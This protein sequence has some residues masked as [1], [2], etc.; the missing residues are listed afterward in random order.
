MKRVFTV[1]AAVVVMLSLT[2][3][4][5]AKGTTINLW[6]AGTE[7]PFMKTVNEEIL[8]LFRRAYPN[9]DLVVTFVPWGDLSTKL[10]TAFAAK[11]PP[12]VF[13][14]GQAA[15]AGFAANQSI[16]PL[17]K[18]I[19]KMPDAKDFGPTIDSGAYMG[20]RYMLPMNGAGRLLIY[21][22]DF[23]REAGLDPNRPPTT[24]E[25][26]RAAAIAQTI[27]QGSR[28]VREG[29]DIP[30]QGIDAQQIYSN[31]LWQNGGDFI[32]QDGKK[33]IFNSKEGVE[34]L[35]FIVDLIYKDKCTN[36]QEERPLGNVQP[37]ASGKVAMQFAVPND[38]KLIEVYSPDVYKQIRV[39]PPLMNKEQVALYSY[40]GLFMAKDSKNKDAAWEVMQF[41][42]SPAVLGKICESLGMLP[43]RQS[44]KSAPFI[45]KDYRIQAYVEGMAYGRG[46]PNVPAWV[47]V[48]DILAT[49]IEKAAFGVMSPQDALDKAAAEC[50]AALAGK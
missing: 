2:S 40:S 14:H 24:W 28:I 26:L 16:E 5:Y 39:A 31:F 7:A 49:Y 12:D 22:A 29:L 35:Q 46:N 32:S 17:D 44:L 20:K 15:T 8:P 36:T 42:T 11:L 4:G 27:R 25:E 13:M 47:K 45:A 21:R 50:N 6:F 10:G 48:R 33:A 37:I 34:A 3:I 41:M 19:A 43:P 38:I 1:I 9:I 18:Y 30:T 23:F